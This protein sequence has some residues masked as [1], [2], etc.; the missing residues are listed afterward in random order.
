MAPK[1]KFCLS[2]NKFGIVDE[3]NTIKS[4]IFV[5][6]SLDRKDYFIMADCGKLKAKVPSSWKKSFSQGLVIPHKW[7]FSI[8]INMY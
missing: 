6:D 2:I 4:F 7:N 1:I 5:S 3:H 8:I